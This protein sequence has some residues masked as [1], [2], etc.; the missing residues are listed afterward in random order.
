MWRSGFVSLI[1]FEAS[2]SILLGIIISMRMHH[3]TW[4]PKSAD[5]TFM[6]DL[7]ASGKTK[8]FCHNRTRLSSSLDPYNFFWDINI[9]CIILYASDQEYWLEKML[10]P[11]YIISGFEQ[12]KEKIYYLATKIIWN[13]SIFFVKL[14]S[15]VLFANWNYII[16]FELKL[17]YYLWIVKKVPYWIIICIFH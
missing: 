8:S 1:L 14:K 2:S 10:L 3:G 16:I 9:T 5:N 6:I 17:Y 15:I 12:R 7:S 11:R 4:H 13:K